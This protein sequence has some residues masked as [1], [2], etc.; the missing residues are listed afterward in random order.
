MTHL[1]TLLSC[2]SHKS[3]PSLSLCV[4]VFT[5]FQVFKKPHTCVCACVF[6]H[7]SGLFPTETI[8]GRTACLVFPPQSSG[9]G[10]RVL[11]SGLFGKRS[12]RRG[13]CYGIAERTSPCRTVQCHSWSALRCSGRVRT[14]FFF[15]ALQVVRVCFL[16]TRPLTPAPT[17]RLS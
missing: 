7:G 1:D 14:C 13:P 17:G 9:D 15:T 11:P 16:T 10:A 12:P 6:V 2:I 4:C 5:V 8:K 3:T